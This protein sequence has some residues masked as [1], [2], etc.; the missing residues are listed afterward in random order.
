MKLTRTNIQWTVLVFAILA[1]VTAAIH[2]ASPK[3]QNLKIASTHTMQF[4]IFDTS[5]LEKL[6][7]VDVP[8]RDISEH[9]RPNALKAFEDEDLSY[10]LEAYHGIADDYDVSLTEFTKHPIAEKLTNQ[11][12]GYAVWHVFT[13]SDAQTLLTKLRGMS[14]TE[15]DATNYFGDENVQEDVENLRRAHQSLQAQLSLIDDGQLGVW[16]VDH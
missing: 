5:T 9:L 15:K 7:S 1:I 3:N 2:F 8:D 11:T 12:S 10:C 13:R 6:S 16:R 4:F 14:I